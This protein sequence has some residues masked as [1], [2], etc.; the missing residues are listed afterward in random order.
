MK[1]ENV[2]TRHPQLEHEAKVYQILADKGNK[3]VPAIRWYGTE[4]HFN[5]MVMDLLGPSIEDLFEFCHRRFTLK[6][7]LMLMDQL[8]VQLEAIHAKGFVHRDIKPENIVI[9]TGLS[10]NKLNL[11][12]FGLAKQYRNPETMLHMPFRDDKESLTGTARYASIN[13]HKGVGK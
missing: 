8:L 1:L 5:A 10:Q 3:I 4:G 2:D 9:G 6:T 13:N 7:V 12:D 11:I